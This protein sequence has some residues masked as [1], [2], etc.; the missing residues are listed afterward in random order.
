[1][2]YKSPGRFT[3]ATGEALITASLALLCLIAAPAFAG[4]HVVN[5]LPVTFSNAS[6]SADTWDTV[7]IA[8]TS[9]T[10]ASDGIIFNGTDYWVV[11]G[12]GDT[13]VFGNSSTNVAHGAR[14]VN[15][16]GGLGSD[17]IVIKDLVIL[18]RPIGIDT[19]N[20]DPNDTLT[21]RVEGISTGYS[22][23][24]ILVENCRIEI[25]AYSSHGIDIGRG[26]SQ[27]YRHIDIN[28][29]SPGFHNRCQ[30]DACGIRMSGLRRSD[31]TGDGTFNVRIEDVNVERVSHCGIY[32]S[33]YQGMD[34][35]M[36]VEAC[37]VVV[38]SKNIMYGPGEG[39]T[40]SGRANCYGIQFT[41][42]GP[43]SY[44]KHCHITADEGNHG[45]RG[46]QLVSADGTADN[47]VVICST[48]VNVHEDADVQFRGT[49]GYF[50]CAIKI[51]QNCYGV[52]VFDNTF[53]YVADGSV[54]W[55]TTTG[56][57][58]TSGEAG[59][60]EHWSSN[61]P[62]FDVS[63]ERNLFRAI[64]RSSGAYIAGF[65]FDNCTQGPDPS[66][67][68]KNNRIESDYTGIKWGGY[69]G[70]AH[71]F[72]LI[73]DTLRVVD[74]SNTETH[75]FM[76]GYLNMNYNTGDNLLR[77]M[78]FEG[79]ASP[80]D[81]EFPS[82]QGTADLT[83]QQTLRVY[84]R[85]NNDQ[86]VS[87]A[88][89]TVRNNYNQVVLSGTSSSGGLVSGPV[90]YL[91]QTRTGTDSTNF[92]NF[93]VMVSK[94]SDSNS[95]NISVGWDNFKDTLDLS[96]T[97]GDGTW[98]EEDP[99]DT[100]PPAQV[101]DLGAVPGSLDLMRFE[102]VMHANN[103]LIPDQLFAAVEFRGITV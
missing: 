87:G 53:I 93:S 29:S 43:G 12:Q 52:S 32:G 36:Q 10:S 23:D 84:V 25:Q 22:C 18:N 96:N 60:Y 71:S 50:P 55:G 48:Y 81:I 19:L 27:V 88:S 65:T 47:P 13:I 17:Y 35:I 101:D 6:H 80:N 8:G 9:L 7:T 63:F 59:L 30:F 42:A 72:T 69:D 91:Y 100:I 20:Y 66:F 92:N 28:H 26:H 67:V 64:D 31:I 15:I 1:M 85:G 41:S 86:P 24:Y 75:S 77:D 57:Y 14:G 79:V 5:S 58:Y 90:S 56:S 99:I 94:G 44:I 89:V 78:V 95:G 98:Q 3:A 38:S 70:E 62:P 2:N 11:E 54:N 61:S 102:E 74:T 73:G 46:I 83:F 68:F 45:G 103:H 34:A 51:R 39:G 40:C 49:Y 21:G 33:A 82:S 4:Q 16:G 37:T 97:L 76:V